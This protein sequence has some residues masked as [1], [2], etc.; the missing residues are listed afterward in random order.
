M[1]EA[2]APASQ[3]AR[4]LILYAM[5]AAGG[6]VAYVPL[7][8]VL[9]PVRVSLLAGDQDVVWLSYL[10]FGGAI[11]ASLA[12]I[13]FGWLSDVTG[14]RRRW[15]VTGLGLSSTMLILIGRAETF[16]SLIGFIILWQIGLNLML[17]PLAA[18]A[19]D[20]VPDHQK[21]TLGGLLAFSPAIG[22]LAGSFVTFPEL[23]LPETRLTLVAGIVAA[24]VLPALLFGRPK[25]MP[26]LME[27]IEGPAAHSEKRSSTRTVIA[28]MWSA[29]LL[30][31]IAEAALFAFLFIW[32]RSISSTFRDSDAATVFS[33]ALCVAVPIAMIAGRLSDRLNRPIAP[34]VIFVSLGALGLWIMA[35][36]T[37]LTNAI[38]GYLIF[39]I[40]TT[41][42]LALHSSQ[43]LRVL[44]RP[45]NRGRD[46]GLFNLTNT[47]PS[48]IMPWLTLLLVPSFGFSGLFVLLGL[49]TAAASLLLAG[50]AMRR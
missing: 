13:A 38:V 10:T 4:F 8:T 22:A 1:A 2:G 33:I 36:S 29:R 14:H 15:I 37:T 7:L 46:L 17:A 24:M 44:P 21:G 41:V 40:T 19:G 30:V 18:W 23:A 39:G 5:A 35:V 42:F 32:L 9:L 25:P 50:L 49:L 26:Q 6:A 43:T 45:Q 20:C 47:V 12:N 48:L 11:A 34:L 16:E 27:P 3:S 28:A 31:Q